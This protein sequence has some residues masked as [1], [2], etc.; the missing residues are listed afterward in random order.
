MSIMQSWDG[1][2]WYKHTCGAIPRELNVLKTLTALATPNSIFVDV[3]A[4]VGFYT[5]RMAKLCKHVHAIEPNPESADILRKNL[6]LNKINNVTLHQVACGD[7]NEEKTLYMASECSTLYERS[8]RSQ[9]NVHVRRLD[10]LVSHCDIVK[11]DVEG[12]EEKVMLGALRLVNESK[13][14]WVIEHHEGAFYPEVV[15]SIGRI[16][17]IMKDYVRITFDDGR[18]LY[19]H[20]SK[21]NQIPQNFLKRMLTLHYT[22]I[23]FKNIEKGRDW[24]HG[25]PCTWWYGFSTMDFIEQL[26]DHV[27]NEPEWLKMVE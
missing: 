7:K 8:G 9:V 27:L 5:V 10:E 15:D 14:V 20:K 17:E 26:P 18:C 22:W 21:I 1:F 4:H 19:I 16:R 24:Y 11:I 25:I 23:V 13:P 12:W 6:E 3:G 2:L